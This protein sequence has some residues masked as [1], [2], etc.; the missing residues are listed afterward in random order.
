MKVLIAMDSFKGSLTS[1][2]ACGAVER[3][4]LRADKS[5]EIVKIPMADGGEGTIEAFI[6]A[7]GGFI[8]GHT[9]SGLF[10]EKIK[11]YYGVINEGKTAVV[12][13][14]V[15]SGITLVKPERLNPMEASTFGTG[16]IILKA[17]NDGFK[18]IVVAGRERSQRR[19]MGALQALGINSGRKRGGARQGRQNAFKGPENRYIRYAPH[20]GR[21]NNYPGMRR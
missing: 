2:E 15:A 13:T 12:E 20:A 21:N 14:A 19:G 9:V 6:A 5:S 18:D 11:G 7:A 16:E 17:I 10:G 3:G 1:V 4:I 8:A